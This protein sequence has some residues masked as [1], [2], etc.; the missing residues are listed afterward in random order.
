M[1]WRGQR[2][3]D[4]WMIDN[5]AMLRAALVAYAVGGITLGITYWELMFQLLCYSWIALRLSTP[6]TDVA[7]RA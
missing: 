5:A 3:G 4:P 1:I 7:T 2:I 6:A